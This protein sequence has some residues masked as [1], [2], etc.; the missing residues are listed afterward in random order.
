MSLAVAIACKVRLGVY[1]K[2]KSQCDY[3]QP[4]NDAKTIFDDILDVI[5]IDSVVSYFQITYCLQ[6]KVIEMLGFNGSH[7]IYPD[8]KILNIALCYV[9]KLNQ[10][11]IALFEDMFG[12]ASFFLSYSSNF[13]M[14]FSDFFKDNGDS[15]KILKLKIQTRR[16]AVR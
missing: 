16:T 2:K 4:R 15:L 12:S 13:L 10:I 6:L 14:K 9:L 7:F 11:K 5:D 1:L 3:I 8:F